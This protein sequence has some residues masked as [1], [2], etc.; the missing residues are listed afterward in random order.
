VQRRLNDLARFYSLLGRL[1]RR[2]GGRRMLTSS[3]GRSGWP[4]RGV[5]FFMEDG[6]CRTDSGVGLRV[7]RVGTH[8]L[9]SSSRTTLWKR[10]SQHKGQKA[11][12]GGNHRGSIFRLLVGSTLLKAPGAAGPTWGVKNSAPNDVRILEQPFEQ[13][14]SRIIGAMPF[15]WLGIDDAPGAGSMRGYV[16]RNAIALLS[17]LAKPPLDGPS[18]NWR[19]TACDRGKGLVRDSGLWNQN[20]VDEGY[21]PAFLDVLE[22]LVNEGG[23]R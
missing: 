15:L 8:A 6:E 17:N 23:A 16:E 18:G 12:G 3:D 4:E 9:T 20:H 1:E 14:V 7:V 11:S 5:Y 13:E 10:L 2:I 19:G 21:D 22:R